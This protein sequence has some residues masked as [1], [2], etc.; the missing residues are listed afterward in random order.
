MKSSRRQ[1]VQAMAAGAGAALFGARAQAS[2]S[3]ELFTGYP[4]RLGMLVDLSLCIGCRKC[5]EACQQAN[6]LPPLGVPLEDKSIFESRRRTDA[7][8]YTVVNRFARGGPDQPPVFVKQQ[9]MHCE[10]PACAS[11]CLVGAFSKSKEGAVLYNK[12]L[13]LGCRYCMIACPFNIPAY[14]YHN[15]TS[16]R[17]RKCTLCYDRV[18]EGQKPACASICPNEAITFGK[19]SELIKLAGE[20]LLK[21]PGKYQDH[22]Y[23]LTEAGGTSWLYL[24]EV[25][26]AALGFP[27]T[28]GTKPFAEYTRGFLS[29]VPVVFVVWP[30]LLGGF[31]LFTKSQQA[32]VAD[33]GGRRTVTDRKEP[34]S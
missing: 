21:H 8:H 32:Q 15:P 31:Y 12:D 2:G 3:V 1:F 14:E 13:C 25:P 20:K 24:S 6:G 16:P 18:K 30:A 11:A 10:E 27:M 7:K 9:C 26:F 34:E 19:R 23:G 17:V 33:E 5:E 4:D 22:L 29:A 28:L